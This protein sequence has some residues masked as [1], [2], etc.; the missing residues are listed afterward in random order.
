MKLFYA[1]RNNSLVHISEV[2]SGLDCGCQCPACGENLLARKG[3][4][5][6]HHFAH[7][8]HSQCPESNL[9]YIAKY[10]A[11]S[12]ISQ[13]LAVASHSASGSGLEIVWRCNDGCGKEHCF[14]LMKT[15]VRE[16]VMERDLGACQPDIT[17]IDG[18][19]EPRCLIEIVLTHSPEQTVFDYARE[20]GYVVIEFDISRDPLLHSIAL[21]ENKLIPSFVS[22]CYDD[23]LVNP[24]N[25]TRWL[26][27]YE[28]SRSMDAYPFTLDSFG[29]LPDEPPYDR[30]REL[31][32]REIEQGMEE[33]FSFKYARKRSKW[34]NRWLAALS[35][36]RSRKRGLSKQEL[37]RSLFPGLFGNNPGF[38]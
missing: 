4:Y 38:P 35:E 11:W 24:A 15:G 1:I 18:R 22:L 17:L 13:K 31:C 36:T 27:N 14:D 23:I 9:H 8:S 19:S 33:T 12:R 10:I 3:K 29:Y 16:A 7:R 26:L 6:S 21:F 2:S 5:R 37:G 28:D 20:R 30:C 34:I 32:R 25:E